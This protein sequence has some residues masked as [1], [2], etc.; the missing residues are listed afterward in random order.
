MG[1]ITNCCASEKKKRQEKNTVDFNKEINGELEV[2]TLTP[3]EEE[4]P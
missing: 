1:A 4:G 2:E 3:E